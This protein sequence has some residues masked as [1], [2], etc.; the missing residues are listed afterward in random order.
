M[1]RLGIDIGGTTVKFGVVDAQFHIL[2][3]TAIPTL[4]DRP[5]EALIADIAAASKPL[6][7]K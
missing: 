6:I 3:Q 4:A 7:E 1:T 5:A 2:E